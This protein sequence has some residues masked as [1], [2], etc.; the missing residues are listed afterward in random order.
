MRDYIKR[1]FVVLFFWLFALF[2]LWNLILWNAIVNSQYL[3]LNYPMYVILI[4]LSVYIVACYGIVPTHVRFSRGI[5]FSIWLFALF[6][7]KF[8]LA[9]NWSQGIYFWDIISVFWVITLIIGPTGLIFSQK[10]KKQKEEK[11]LEIIEV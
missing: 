7:G 10:I 2:L 8:I 5:L 6:L 11:D 9:N 1:V 4:A 3:D